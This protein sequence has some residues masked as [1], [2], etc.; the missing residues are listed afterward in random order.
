MVLPAAAE[1]DDNAGQT[2]AYRAGVPMNHSVVISRMGRV[3]KLDYQ[4]IGADGEHYNIREI[5]DYDYS[6][7][8]AVAIYQGDVQV[9]SGSF[10][11]G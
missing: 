8:P 7:K 10:E 2:D 4:L 11:Y 1:P 3:L 9:A 5:T 6:K